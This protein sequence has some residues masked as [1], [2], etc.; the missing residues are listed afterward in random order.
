MSVLSQKDAKR[1]LRHMN[2]DP[3]NPLAKI[4]LERGREVMKKFAISFKG[5]PAMTPAGWKRVESKARERNDSKPR[6]VLIE[7]ELVCPA[8]PSGTVERGRGSKS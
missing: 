8:G 4:S 2:E 3:P 6:P 7:T 5:V 1:L